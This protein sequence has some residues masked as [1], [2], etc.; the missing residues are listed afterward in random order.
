MTD[1]QFKALGKQL[2]ALLYPLKSIA[3]MQ[4]VRELYP[5]V[6]RQQLIAKYRALELAAQEAYEA[7]KRAHD[8]LTPNNLSHEE[9]VQKFGQTEA[10]LQLSHWTAALKH[11]NEARAAVSSFQKEHRLIARLIGSAERL[12]KGDYDG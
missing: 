6:E 5:H 4:L 7:Q 1:E 11:S 8:E 3:I 2:D 10:T 9:R 12:G